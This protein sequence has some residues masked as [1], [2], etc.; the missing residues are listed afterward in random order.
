MLNATVHIKLEDRE[1]EHVLRTDAQRWTPD[2]YRRVDGIDYSGVR[3]AGYTRYLFRFLGAR[4][5]ATR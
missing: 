5:V 3:W 1:Y 4:H 2:S